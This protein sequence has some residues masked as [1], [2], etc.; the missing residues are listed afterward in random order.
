MALG[1]L[2]VHL[3]GRMGVL[4]YLIYYALKSETACVRCGS[5]TVS[6]PPPGF[7]PNPNTNAQYIPQDLASKQQQ[8][9]A[10]N[11]QPANQ[12]SGGQS[13][14]GLPAQGSGPKPSSAAESWEDVSPMAHT[15]CPNCGQ[16]FAVE[17]KR[18]LTVTCPSCGTSGT[19]PATS[20]GSGDMEV[21]VYTDKKQRDLGTEE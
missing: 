17:K 10:P 16:R 13:V 21:S 14:H 1:P 3:R 11:Q 12:L 15:T 7:V 20:E 5:E 2:L 19:L 8:L 18:P 4:I 6:S 9:H